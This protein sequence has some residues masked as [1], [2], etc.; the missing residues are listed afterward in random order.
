MFTGTKSNVNKAAGVTLDVSGSTIQ[1][2]QKLQF[3][4]VVIDSHLSW[5]VHISQVVKKCNHILVSFYRLRHY[6]TKEAL[7]LLIETFVFTHI[8][9]CLCVWGGAT[10]VQLNKIQKLINFAARIVTGVKKH[11]P[12]SS[13]LKLLNW[14]RIEQLVS[15]RD[16]IKV[17]KLLTDPATPA[18]VRALLVPR[19]AVSAR[20]SRA[21]ESGALQLPRRRLTSS[22]RHFSFRAVAGWNALPRTARAAKTLSTFKR[23]ILS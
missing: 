13:S 6:F 3:L 4:G 9:Y 8:Y 22:Q 1:A 12:I 7:K 19:A 15:R 18:A 21:S 17:F 14:P 5:E 23:A 16:S 10:K 11:E 20:A 2:S